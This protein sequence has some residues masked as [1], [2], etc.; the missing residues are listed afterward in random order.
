M[1]GG[2]NDQNSN[3]NSSSVMDTLLKFIT[4]DKLGVSLTDD[5]SKREAAVVE[6]KKA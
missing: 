3:S 6:D 2:S 4:I 5:D 1:V